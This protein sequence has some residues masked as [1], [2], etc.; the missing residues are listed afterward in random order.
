[1]KKIAVIFAALVILLNTATVFANDRVGMGFDYM[2]L[3][4][5]FNNSIDQDMELKQVRGAIKFSEDLSLE[6]GYAFGGYDSYTSSDLKVFNLDLK[7]D[8]NLT[9]SSEIYLGVGGNYSKYDTNF[10]GSEL[11]NIKSK[12]LDLLFGLEYKLNNRLS[13]FADGRYGIAGDYQIYS[14][15]LKEQEYTQDGKIT[16]YELAESYGL[17][18][19]LNFAI[20]EDLKAKLGYTIKH[21][22]INNKS[23]S[24]A[25]IQAIDGND[26]ISNYNFLNVD[27]FTQGI[28]FGVETNF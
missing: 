8:F 10:F 1:M 21:D 22:T 15:Y 25:G 2:K 18:T 5:K 20:T 14:Q 23:Y 13:L 28:F 24:V 26:V 9:P 6:A 4:Y 11:F 12:D 16:D 3:N 27:R 7:K 19:G 17:E